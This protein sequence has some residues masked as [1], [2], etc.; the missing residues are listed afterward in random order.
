[1]SVSLIS[2]VQLMLCHSFCS[3]AQAC[4]HMDSFTTFLSPSVDLKGSSLYKMICWKTG[5]CPFFVPNSLLIWL[6]PLGALTSP[7]WRIRGPGA[8]CAVPGEWLG[9]EP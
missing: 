5:I 8:R 2:A 1:M 9:G 3:L 4:S 7:S 6:E